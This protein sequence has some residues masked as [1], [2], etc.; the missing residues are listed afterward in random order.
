MSIHSTAVIHKDTDID[1]SVEIGPYA[2]VHAHV[3]IGSGTTIGSHAVIGP[4]TTIGTHC[5]IYAHAA[6]GGDS[7]DKKFNKSEDT[8]LEIGNYNV[9]RE[10]ATLNRGTE[11]G[12]V[13]KLGDYCWMMTG[14]H[15]AHNCVVG[16]H[17][18]MANSVA[19]A[20][21]VEVEDSVIIGGL[22][23]V[24]QFCR[25]GRL[26]IIGGC[27]KVVQNVPPFM[28]SD[29]NPATVRSLNAI[30]LKRNQFNHTQISHIK[31][32][33][34]ILFRKDMNLS[35]AIE[36]LQQ[37][38]FSQTPEIQELIRFIQTSERGIGF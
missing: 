36:E 3:K 14:A 2:V 22:T 31:K 29:G 9:I 23:G 34:L 33:H 37:E 30:G 26:S 13:T 16:N 6:V 21:H 8:F 17:V 32:A 7:Q 5:E 1:S 28:M 20:G 19:L 27:S 18:V 10:F 38:E 25:I 24:H 35:H 15:V 11:K 12:S 4:N